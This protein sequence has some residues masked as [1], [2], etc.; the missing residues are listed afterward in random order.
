MYPT[1]KG[2]LIS[3]TLEIHP[4]LRVVK[5]DIM[6]V[7]YTLEN[8]YSINIFA[9]ICHSILFQKK[10]ITWSIILRFN[11]S[12]PR[13]SNCINPNR[14]PLPNTSITIHRKAIIIFSGIDKKVSS[15]I[16]SDDIPNV[17]FMFSTTYLL[18]QKGQNESR[19]NM[20]LRRNSLILRERKHL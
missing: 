1:H 5:F 18:R 13:R 11:G 20:L 8:S 12:P 6:K 15:M 4:M 3:N 17:P 9:I 16:K 2:K 14:S 19:I 7:M 10:Y